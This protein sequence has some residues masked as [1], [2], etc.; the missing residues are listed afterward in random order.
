[1]LLYHSMNRIMFPRIPYYD[2]VV[3]V[4]LVRLSSWSNDAIKLCCSFFPLV[5]ELLV[6]EGCFLLSAALG[7]HG[8]VLA[9][10]LLHSIPHQLLE[11]AHIEA[12]SIKEIFGPY[13][14]S[15]PLNG[16]S[17]IHPK[18]FRSI[19]AHHKNGTKENS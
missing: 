16:I 8:G 1:M 12:A 14:T 6:R 15:F 13:S 10:E 3:H 19:D 7:P 9:I 2:I 11:P 18:S 4:G 17:H 5:A